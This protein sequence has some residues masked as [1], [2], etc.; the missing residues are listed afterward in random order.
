MG[1][2]G[3]AP[4]PTALRAL[5]GEKPYRINQHEPR[6]AEVLPEPPAELSDAGREIWDH[7]VTELAAMWLAH[8]ADA[9][10]LHAYVEAV[11]LHAQASVMVRRA[12]P[13]IK[14]RDGAVRTNP[15]VRIQ[16]EAAR[17]MLALAREF[18]L[19]PAS[20]VHLSTEQVAEDTAT[21]LLG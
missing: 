3:P 15:A 16:R 2:R 8:R 13:L 4:K 10:A 18:G 21:R 20:R 19:T 11:E 14:D 17:T 1:R 6:P 9:H 5:H 12:G 7:I